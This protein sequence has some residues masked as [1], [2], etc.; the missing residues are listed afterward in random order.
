A[1]WAGVND[2]LW[3]RK[4]G[5]PKFYAL[6]GE[7]DSVRAFAEDDSGAL[8]VGMRSG[9]KRLVDERMEPYPLPDNVRKLAFRK[10]IRDRDGGLWFGTPQQGLVHLHQGRTDVFAQSDGLSGANI[11]ALFEDREGNI[12]VSTS[13]G[14]DRFRDFPIA[15][16]TV[17]Q[18]LSTGL[19]WS[20]LAARD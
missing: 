4:P 15:T 2:G 11:W 5:P 13:D 12:W 18:G 10:M 1:L 8:L 6:P 19:V 7:I 16:F 9:T 17:S 20:V 14:L 3:R